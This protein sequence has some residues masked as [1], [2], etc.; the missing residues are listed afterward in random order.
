MTPARANTV[1]AREHA[2][3]T[4]AQFLARHGPTGRETARSAP[5]V[6]PTPARRPAR[7]A[8]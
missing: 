7:S 2:L 6:S 1:D 4:L 3:R 8:S 5:E